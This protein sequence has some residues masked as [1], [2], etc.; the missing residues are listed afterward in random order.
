MRK[1]RNVLAVTAL[2]AF[3]SMGCIMM[4]DLDPDQV[5]AIRVLED[6]DPRTLV[7]Y[8]HVYVENQVS[9]G[10]L[11]RAGIMTVEKLKAQALRKYGDTTLLYNV[12]VRTGGGD[13]NRTFVGY[14]M[15]ARR[16]AN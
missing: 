6:P 2:A 14:A 11:A 4:T 9:E 15:A 12:H 16:L 5:K 1:L 3:S 8:G 10:D 13:T 7:D